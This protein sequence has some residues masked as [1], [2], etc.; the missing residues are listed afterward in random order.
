MDSAGSVRQRFGQ[1]I[2]R[3][4]E[5]KGWSQ[6]R[7]AAE[8]RLHVT[9]LSEV[10]HGKRNISLDNIAKL[11]GALDVPLATLFEDA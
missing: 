11:A 4:R 5:A 6:E 8:A 9:Y 1:R 10:E 2:R 7:L 3:L